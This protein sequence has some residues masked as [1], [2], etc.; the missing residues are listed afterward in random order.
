MNTIESN[1]MT[2]ANHVDCTEYLLNNIYQMLSLSNFYLLTMMIVCSVVLYNK[3]LRLFGRSSDNDDTKTEVALT[4]MGLSLTEQRTDIRID[5]FIDPTNS[6]DWLYPIQDKV[7]WDLCQMSRGTYWV[8][9]EV[10][11]AGDL[12]DWAKLTPDEQYFIKHVLGFFSISDFVVNANLESDFV[13]RVT[14]LELK[15]L[16]RY[17]MMIEDTHSNMYALLIETYIQDPVEKEL[18]KH[19]AES[20]PAIQKKKEWAEKYIKDGTE[21]ERL[22]AFAIVEGI[23]FS[24]SFCSIFWLKKQGK[25][26]GLTFSNELISRDEGIHRDTGIYVYNKHVINKLSEERIIC[27]IKDAVEVETFFV[28][29]SLKVKLI[30]MNSDS[31]VQY[32]KYIADNLALN[33]IGKTIFNV[34]NPFDW[35]NLISMQSKTNFFEKRVDAYSKQKTMSKPTD[36]VVRF[37]AIY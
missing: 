9:E 25:M 27:M 10:D 19:S 14:I 37:D 26:P 12:S 22:V 7:L 1:I 20:Y 21:V 8:A 16:Y 33:L 4:P 24:S 34:E 23:F 32:V 28:E 17:Q 5:P 3:V 6:R 18:I 15:M 29:E 13:E 11:L 2:Y 30:G 31:M 36:N 35:M